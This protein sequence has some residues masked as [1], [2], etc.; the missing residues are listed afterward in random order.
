[1]S[2]SIWC[3]VDYKDDYLVHY[4]VLGMKWGQHRVQVNQAKAKRAKA[5]G[6]KE[7]YSKYSAKAN[8][9]KQKHIRLSGGKKAYD[10][11]KNESLG[12]SLVKSALLGTYGTMKYNEFRS[13]GDSQMLSGLK[14]VG[15]SAVNSLSY[16]TFSIVE[17]RYFRIH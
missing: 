3:N 5:L 8:R 11:T 4:G 17:P 1:M 12:K 10:Y 9:I 16:G 13:N 14:A 15:S 7:A 6:N 2:E